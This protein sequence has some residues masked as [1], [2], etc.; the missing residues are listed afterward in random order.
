MKKDLKF[1]KEKMEKR[2][3]S[4]VGSSVSTGTQ[5]TINKSVN[6]NKLKARI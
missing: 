2:L 3:P 4:A 5:I 1:E 6:I